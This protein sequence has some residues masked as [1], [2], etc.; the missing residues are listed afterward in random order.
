MNFNDKVTTPKTAFISRYL[1]PD[2]PFK[3]LLE[4]QG[5][6]VQGRA[7]VALAPVLFREVPEADWIFFTS[8]NGVQCFF[9]GIKALGLPLPNVHWAAIGPATAAAMQVHGMEP[10][11]TGSGNP[12]ETA[13]AFIPWTQGL[14]VLMPGARQRAGTIVEQLAVHA[15]VSQLVVYDNQMTPDPPAL[16]EEVLVFTSPMNGEAYF[17]L[18]AL[19]AGQRVVAIGPTTAEAL[20]QFDPA[21]AGSPTEEALVRAVLHVCA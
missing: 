10:R 8:P 7:L 5:W 3:R 21:V 17:R 1:N 2:S 12:A 6:Q 20:K 18:H 9:E 4:A 15:D 11:F 13:A 19:L 14:R 16:L